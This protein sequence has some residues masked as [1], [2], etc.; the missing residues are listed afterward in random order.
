MRPLLTA[1]LLLLATTA[2]IG[3]DGAA[4][5]Y[6]P[7][8]G[9]YDAAM[10]A[11]GAEATVE[12]QPR[13]IEGR[14]GRAVVVNNDNWLSFPLQGNMNPAQGAVEF[15]LQPIDWVGDNTEDSHFWVGAAGG[16][17]FTSTSSRAGGTSSCTSTPTMWTGTSPSR[18]C[19]SRGGSRASGTTRW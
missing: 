7:F 18:T 19:P 13:F 5:L 12:G 3:Q 16:T 11:G 2:C 15:W 17:G 14:V 9:E 10:A 1:L 8:D 4:T 6:A